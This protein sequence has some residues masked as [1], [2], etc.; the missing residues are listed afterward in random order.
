[1]FHMLMTWKREFAAGKKTRTRIQ[2]WETE[3]RGGK[4]P[5][6]LLNTSQ[7]KSTDR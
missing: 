1:M 4:Q 3:S 6:V 5:I 2:N 7:I